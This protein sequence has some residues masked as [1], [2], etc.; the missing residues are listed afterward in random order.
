MT[1]IE[2]MNTSW[3]GDMLILHVLE[4]ESSYTVTAEFVWDS[5]HHSYD[6]VLSP[7]QREHEEELAAHAYQVWDRWLKKRV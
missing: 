5:W 4:A 1:T 2:I 7:P 3:Q 6:V